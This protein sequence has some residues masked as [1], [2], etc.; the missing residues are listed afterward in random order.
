[1][2]ALLAG[3]GVQ[4][5]QIYGSSDA[6]GGYPTGKPVLPE[7]LARTVYHA[8]GIDDHQLEHIQGDGRPVRLLTD[9]DVLPVL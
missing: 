6:I 9:G 4:G 1:M 7:D 8:L 3:G 5:G 2:S